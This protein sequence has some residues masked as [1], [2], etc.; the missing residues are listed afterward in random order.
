MTCRIAMRLFSLLCAL[1]RRPWNILTHVSAKSDFPNLR[2]TPT[3]TSRRRRCDAKPLLTTAPRSVR[4]VYLACHLKL[5]SSLLFFSSAS[6]HFLTPLERKS[7]CSFPSSCYFSSHQ[8]VS[9]SICSEMCSAAGPSQVRPFHTDLHLC[10]FLFFCIIWYLFP[11]LSLSLPQELVHFHFHLSQTHPPSHP[12]P[13]QQTTACPQASSRKPATS[14][15]FGTTLSAKIS[16]LKGL[17][18]RGM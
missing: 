7:C 16:V 11:S 18:S 1:C 10:S 2:A 5:H 17:T 8:A 13:S 12:T 6:I 14:S 9:G 15:C 4:A 3:P